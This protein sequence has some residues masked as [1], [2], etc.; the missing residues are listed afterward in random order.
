MKN[1]EL[2]DKNTTAFI[3]GSQQKAAQ[4]MLDFDYL[5]EREKPSVAAFITPT[6]TGYYKLFWGVKEVLIPRYITVKDA[7]NEHSVIDVIVSC[8][9]S[10]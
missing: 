6:G 8:A 9:T 7:L 5:C 3:Y 10:Q 1:Y 2:F 4:R